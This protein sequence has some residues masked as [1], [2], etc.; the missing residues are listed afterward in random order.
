MAI[1]AAVFDARHA[2]EWPD[3][4]HHLPSIN[5]APLA[6]DST[7]PCSVVGSMI[8][9]MDK[10]AAES[11][12]RYKAALLRG[13]FELCPLG[14]ALTDYATGAFIEVNDALLAQNGFS[15]DEFLRLTYFDVTPADYRASDRHFHQQLR[16]VGHHGPYEKENLRK[17]GS[18]YPIV[19]RSTMVTD[20]AGRQLIWSIVEDITERKASEAKVLRQAQFDELTG[21]PNRRLFQERLQR[22]LERA[23]RGRHG[24][25]VAMLDLDDFKTVNDRLGHKAGDTILVEAAGRLTACTRATDTVARFG[26]DEFL[27]LLDDIGVRSNAARIMRKLQRAL[28]QPFCVDGR[29]L[30]LRVSSGISHFPADSDD[31]DELIR[32]ADS[33]MYRAKRQGRNRTRIYSMTTGS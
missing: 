26:G 29:V 2:I 6:R 21:L 12:L 17:D 32:L 8:D 24:G 5:A 9:V 10:L 18:R 19:L 4:T 33:A 16:D 1:R 3:G 20:L 14:I 25:A 23:R 28:V 15:R 27:I 13:L 31:Q 30:Q 11:D 22:A 7:V